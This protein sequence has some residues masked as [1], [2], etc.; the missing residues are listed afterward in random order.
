[1]T[2][3]RPTRIYGRRRGRRLRPGHQRLLD[4]VLPQVSLRLPAP[5]EFLDPDQ[6]F[7]SAFEELWLE[8]GFGAGEHLAWQLFR[9]AET[10]GP[11]AFIGIDYF[12]NGS[13]KL[14][15]RLEG[16]TALE[17]LRLYQGEATE[18]LAVLP[19]GSLD[20]VFILFP[21]PWPKE[22]HHKRRLIQ[23]PVGDRIA[24]LL[25]KGGE[26]RLATDDP[27][28]LA[29]IMERFHK[30]PAFEW[31]ARGPTDWRR[32]PVDWPRTRYEEKALEQGRKPY[33]LRYNRR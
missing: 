2:K 18:V 31:T 16:S 4:E 8:I 26:L 3:A 11:A 17:R 5:G 10:D 22:R 12:I 13:A 14:L 23:S 32:R 27:N 30:H 28:Y 1:M 6:I 24:C 19:D 25:K 21:D 33:Y 15:A 20:R 29:W 9:Q 7:A